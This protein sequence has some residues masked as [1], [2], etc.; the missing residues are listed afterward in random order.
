M[1]RLNGANARQR[2]LGREL[3]VASFSL[4]SELDQ[5]AWWQYQEEILEPIRKAIR[6]AGETK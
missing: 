6:E 3:M 2:E 4:P 5:D 1:S